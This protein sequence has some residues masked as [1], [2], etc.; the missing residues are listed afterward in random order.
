MLRVARRIAVLACLLLGA[1]VA[2]AATV[3]IAADAAVYNVGD[4][5]TLTVFTD[6]EG[7]ELFAVGIVVAY[8]GPVTS[9]T[10]T[11]TIPPFWITSS[12]DVVSS[13]GYRL[14]VHALAVAGIDPGTAFGA[15]LT[16]SANAPGTA[17]FTIGGNPN[18]GFS[19]DFGTA[20]PGANVAVTIVP[21]PTTA[22][23]LGL[24]VVGLAL[25]KRRR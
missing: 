25:T 8:T 1:G 2:N 6:S 21:E 4:T 9:L 14:A 24:G 15:T 10:S 19:F 16:F 12:V 22:A 18:N 7:E 17:T 5:I 3:G 13:P 20:V 23:L 11:P